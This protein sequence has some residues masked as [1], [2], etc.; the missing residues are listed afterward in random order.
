MR[1]ELL[2]IGDSHTGALAAA[3]AGRGIRAETMFLSGNFWH[4]GH[5][6][7]HPKAGLFCP[8][9][10][11]VNRDIRA[12][13]AKIGGASLFAPGIP[14]LASFGYHLGR[15][16]RPFEN[17]VFAMTETG[18]DAKHHASFASQGFI[19][20]YVAH[21]RDALIQMLERAH[22]SC[23]LLVVAPPVLNADPMA[24]AMAGIITARLT[25]LGIAVFD[26]RDEADWGQA[27]MA[28]AFC[29]ADGRH[30]NADYGAAVLSRIADRAPGVFGCLRGS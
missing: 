15:M 20:A 5:L 4:D 7:F 9:R 11:G 13:R 19:A 25:A 28:A 16:I 22:Q 18:F 27:P 26:P 2:I 1:P 21:H 30:G 3:A 17:R 6:E 23:D 8:H 29:D 14:V 12:L 10:P 24:F